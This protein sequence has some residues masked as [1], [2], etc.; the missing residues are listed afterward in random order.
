MAVSK[1]YFIS[2]LFFFALAA[3]EPCTAQQTQKKS[4]T[5]QSIFFLQGK[6]SLDSLTKYVHK[7]SGIRF[8]FNSAKVKGSKEIF[9]SKNQYSILAILEQIKKTTSLFYSSYS[10]Y[11]VFQD[12]PPKQKTASTKVIPPKKP[13][14]KAKAASQSQIAIRATPQ[15]DKKVKNT[16]AKLLK[17]RMAK[18]PTANT[19]AAGSK[20]SIKQ[21]NLRP[22][23]SSAEIVVINNNKDDSMVR[24]I[25]ARKVMPAMPTFRNINSDSTNRAIVGKY[26]DGIQFSKSA[27]DK[28]PDKQRKVRSGQ[29]LDLQYGLQ[30]NLNV[31]VYGSA[32]Y[33]IG[34]NGNSQA[35]NALIPGVWVS[36]T[37]GNDKHEILLSFKPEQQYFTGNKIVAISTGPT[38]AQDSTQI[39]KN[40]SVVKTKGIYAGLQYNYHLNSKWTIGAG[41]NFHWQSASLANTRTTGL[42]S[43]SFLSDSSYT[44]KHS[45]AE[46]KYV[47]S[48]FVTGKLEAAYKIG[49]VDIG[50]ALYVPINQNLV[51]FSNSRPV[52]LHV[53]VRWRMK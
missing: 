39:Q 14:V 41:I 10:G 2:I 43:G 38:S 51:A 31:P 33:F 36:K 42:F 8:S 26:L 20:I 30:W 40:T 11:I 4:K 46:W 24:V 52:N 29:F 47:K 12:N 18:R 13:M 1:A 3:S 19:A 32:N 48:S 49:K 35:Y 34:T 37:I 44:I 7:N 28:S 15:I 21:E 6:I 22:I 27:T 53:F 25:G 45:S 5:A 9:F 16:Q 50:G 17:K 23:N